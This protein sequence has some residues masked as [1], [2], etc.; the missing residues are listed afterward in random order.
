MSDI[1]ELKRTELIEKRKVS[2]I[3]GGEEDT[4]GMTKENIQLERELSM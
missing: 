4:V 2:E 1:L 3:G